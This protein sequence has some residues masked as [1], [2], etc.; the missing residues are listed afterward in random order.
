MTPEDEARAFEAGYR[1]GYGNGHCDAEQGEGFNNDPGES[2][3]L[4]VDE[5]GRD[6]SHRQLTPRGATAWGR[7]HLWARRTLRGHR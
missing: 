5:D 6:D 3:C 7:L 2:Y 1:W 4:W